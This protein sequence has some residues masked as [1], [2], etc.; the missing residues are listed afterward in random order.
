MFLYVSWGNE[1]EAA[2]SGLVKFA[3]GRLV[4]ARVEREAEG[5]AGEASQRSSVHVKRR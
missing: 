2:S 3:L 5:G 1:A 4:G